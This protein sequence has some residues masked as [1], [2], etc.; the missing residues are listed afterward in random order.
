MGAV[1]RRVVAVRGSVPSPLRMIRSQGV[2]SVVRKGRY[3][4]TSTVVITARWSESA[5]SPATLEFTV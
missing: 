1:S 4:L 2:S 5:A 3:S